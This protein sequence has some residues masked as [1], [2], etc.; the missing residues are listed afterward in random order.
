[1]TRSIA[2]RIR[3]P[4]IVAIH[5]HTGTLIDHLRIG[6]HS[7]PTGGLFRR[8]TESSLLTPTDGAGLIT[9]GPAVEIRVDDTAAKEYSPPLQPLLSQSARPSARR[10]PP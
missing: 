3:S 1:M 2:S 8:R 6:G 9:T 7:R 5:N 4:A 10:S